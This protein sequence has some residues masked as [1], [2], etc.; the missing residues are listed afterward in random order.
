MH[1]LRLS[2]SECV[3]S[4]MV[5]QTSTVLETMRPAGMEE[6]I[7]FRRDCSKSKERETSET[8]QRKAMVSLVLLARSDNG[9]ALLLCQPESRARNNLQSSKQPHPRRKRLSQDGR[10]SE[11]L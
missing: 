1:G 3:R 9:N 10:S 11:A 2:R 7:E 8:E 4:M 5:V 6:C